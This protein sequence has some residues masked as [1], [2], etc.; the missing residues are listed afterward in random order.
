[1]GPKLIGNDTSDFDNLGRGV[2]IDGDRLAAGAFHKTI[3]IAEEGRVYVFEL[4]GGQWVE[5]TVLAPPPEDLAKWFRFGM[6]V[7]LEGDRLVVRADVF[8][9]AIYLYAFEGGQWNWVEKLRS[10]PGPNGAGG[11]HVLSFSMALSGGRV[12]AGEPAY[13]T[14]DNSIVLFSTAP[15][16]SRSCFCSQGPYCLDDHGG[17][18]TSTGL[19][20]S[21]SAC[22]S[23]SVSVDDLLLHAW[24]L[25]PGQL[26]LLL[27][28]NGTSD[29]PLGDG[30]LC[31]GGSI[32]RFTV[33]AANTYQHRVQ[34]PG[35]VAHS[36]ANFPVAGRIQ[37]GD[38]WHFQYW[39]RDPLGF[40]CSGF[41][42]EASGN[43][44]S[45][46]VTVTFTP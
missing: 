38:T 7:D 28:G 32:F 26:G 43:N 2:A 17:C 25:P 40:R 44:L 45:N 16:S 22:G 36:Q 19:G 3:N 15:G 37:A 31:I 21:L 33:G 41:Q 35:L 12:L 1:M 42:S 10:E 20:V 46:V 18:R 5:H 6:G 4:Q 23:P 29:T 30:R 13:M 27:M 34:G 11:Q 8:R 24:S 9:E 14:G 39:F